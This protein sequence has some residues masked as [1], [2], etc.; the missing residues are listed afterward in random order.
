MF[1]EQ[2]LLKKL[3]KNLFENLQKHWSPEIRNI[4]ILVLCKMKEKHP[5][6]IKAF[7]ILHSFTIPKLDAGINQEELWNVLKYDLKGE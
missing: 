3:A 5:K 1:N 4:S 6:I 2:M 7:E